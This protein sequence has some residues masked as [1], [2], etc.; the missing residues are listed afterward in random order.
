MPRRI[1]GLLAS[2]FLLASA[3]SAAVFIAPKDVELIDASDVIVIGTITQM[4]G[5]FLVG[6]DIA[7]TFEIDVE[8][9]LKGTVPSTMKIRISELGGVVGSQVMGV[10]ASPRY[11]RRNRALIFIQKT[12]DGMHTWGS[13]LGKFD[14]VNDIHNRDLLVRWAAEE[15]MSLWSNDGHPVDDVLREAEGFLSFIEDRVAQQETHPPTP[16]RRRAIAPASSI[17]EE[18]CSYCLEPIPKEELKPPAYWNV[19]PD[20]SG[21]PA[22]AYCQGSPPFRW[23]TFD[24]GGSVTFFVSGSQPGYDSTGAAQRGLAAWTNDAGSNIAYLY[25]GTK[26]TAFVQ[27]GT[28]SIVFNSSSDVPAGAIA[29]SKWYGGAYHTYKGE[30]FVSISEGDVV[31]KSGISVTQKVFDEAVTHELGH[32]LGFRHSDQGTPSSTQAVMKAVLSGAYGATLGPWDAEAAHAVYESATVTPP[33]APANLVATANS[34]TSVILTWTTVPNATS[35][36][37]ERRPPN[38]EF[39]IVGTSTSGTFA[40]TGLTPDTSYLYRVRA[41]NGTTPSAYSNVDHATTTIFLDD[42]L[43]AGTVIK[44]EH[45]L[46]LRTAINAL[47]VTVG[48][49]PFSWTQT[50]GSGIVIRA[51]HILELRNALTPA[52]NARGISPTYTSLSTG[53]VIRTIHIQEL[54]NYVK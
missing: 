33:S 27:D 16:G 19:E 28:N 41:F 24:K 25:G 53:S 49:A 42:P 2:L 9:V 46:Q 20:Q 26:N 17:G 7:T 21:Y 14:F 1:S 52:L 39:I 12:S 6:G 5:E 3:S 8:K 45:I 35:Y 15:D 43:L 29:Y 4:N 34:N 32:T 11:W 48:L 30:Q 54:R 13:E 37:I 40:D 51:A 36:Q 31:V 10:S 44:D 23:D 22:S 38:G 18:K 47:R 50:V